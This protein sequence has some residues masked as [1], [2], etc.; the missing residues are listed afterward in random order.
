MLMLKNNLSNLEKANQ[1][2]CVGGALDIMVTN[3][4]LAAVHRAFMRVVGRSVYG[5][6]KNT[7]ADYR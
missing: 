1:V 2:H 4:Y 7:G 6:G 5:D 3:E